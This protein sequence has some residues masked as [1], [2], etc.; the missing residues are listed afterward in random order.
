MSVEN[1]PSPIRFVSPSAFGLETPFEIYR[2]AVKQFKQ[3]SF[4][5]I[6]AEQIASKSMSELRQCSANAA[7]GVITLIKREMSNITLDIGLR[8]FHEMLLNNYLLVDDSPTQS[9]QQT[10]AK[11]NGPWFDCSL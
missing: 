7:A 8:R 2:N 5:P 10:Y 9:C 1:R 4:N 11:N 6:V 3:V